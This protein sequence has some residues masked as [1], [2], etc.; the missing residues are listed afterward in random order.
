MMIFDTIKAILKWGYEYITNHR[1]THWL[2]SFY[3]ARFQSSATQ[4]NTATTT[5]IESETASASHPDERPT[6]S[7]ADL[8]ISDLATA[9]HP[10]LTF[11]EQL[12]IAKN[13][14]TPAPQA[15]AAEQQARQTEYR[16]N[17]M[18]IQAAS[19]NSHWY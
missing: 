2:Y 10:K 7:S 3:Q 16:K 14:L 11:V 13:N 12:R 15:T 19:Y 6:V 9:N 4:T 17:R 1:Y 8:S 5:I 18:C